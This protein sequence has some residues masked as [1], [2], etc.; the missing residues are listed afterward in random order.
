MDFVKKNL[1]RTKNFVVDNRIAIASV[2][3][4]TAVAGVVIRVQH[5]AIRELEGFIKSEG[6][7]DKLMD[8]FDIID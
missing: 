3:T 7:F 8:S 5:G 6:L 2:I 1:T 4:V